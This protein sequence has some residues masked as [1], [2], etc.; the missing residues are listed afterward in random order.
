MVVMVVSPHKICLND[1]ATCKKYVAKIIML[2]MMMMI[3]LLN[4]VRK[5]KFVTVIAKF[6]KTSDE[7]WW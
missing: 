4:Y 5:D 7:I 3:I 2:L 6:L 1:D